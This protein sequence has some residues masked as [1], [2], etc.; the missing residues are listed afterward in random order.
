ML[1]PETG[2]EKKQKKKEMKNTFLLFEDNLKKY[3]FIKND[4]EYSP[5]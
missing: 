3:S 4:A 1:C 5:S 2:K